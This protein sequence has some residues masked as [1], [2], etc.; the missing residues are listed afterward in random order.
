LGVGVQS[1]PLVTR[2]NL[3][4]RSSPRSRTKRGSCSRASRSSPTRSSRRCS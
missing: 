1:R 2:A 3:R 4:R